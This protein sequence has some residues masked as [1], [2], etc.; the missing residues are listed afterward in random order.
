MP[1][2]DPYVEP[3]MVWPAELSTHQLP[4]KTKAVWLAL[5][6]DGSGRLTAGEFGAFMR[7]GAGAQRSPVMESQAR[8][9]AFAASRDVRPAGAR[10][11]YQH[12]RGRLRKARG[13][14]RSSRTARAR[15]G[16]LLQAERP[17][18]GRRVPSNAA[19][20]GVGGA[21]GAAAV[22]AATPRA[23]ALEPLL[24]AARRAPPAAV[25]ARR[26]P[27]AAVEAAGGGRGRA[28]RLCRGGGGE[29]GVG[30]GR[31]RPRPPARP[32]SASAASPRRAAAMQ[33][34]TA[35][36][37]PARPQSARPQSTGAASASASASCRSSTVEPSLLQV[38]QLEAEGK[39][40]EAAAILKAK[41][42][43]LNARVP[44]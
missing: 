40:E 16:A 18:A 1:R 32:A 28:A 23:D 29:A 41:L 35:T 14:T 22:G 42:D 33:Q 21:A 10:A 24:K 8:S 30:D 5:D 27:C 44:R 6:Q 38:K 2:A 37:R 25:G 7:K 17:S 9:R 39:F 4:E 3:R 20:V 43:D 11:A 13:A 34:N 31:A 26:E 12:A 36:G 15:A 19:A